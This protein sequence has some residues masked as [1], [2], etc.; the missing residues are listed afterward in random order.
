[1][2]EETA[3]EI[4]KTIGPLINPRNASEW[5]GGMFLRVRVRIDTTCPLRHGR[6]VNFKEGLEWWVSFQYERLPNICFWCGMF[7][8]DD[9]ECNI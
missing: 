2:S 7:L 5:N 6:R 1:M 8:H 9:K 3:K 4:G